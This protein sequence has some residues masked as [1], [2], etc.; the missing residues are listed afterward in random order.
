MCVGLILLFRLVD[1]VFPD[2]FGAWSFFLLHRERA[3]VPIG[4]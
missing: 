3:R 4:G 1:I 2:P